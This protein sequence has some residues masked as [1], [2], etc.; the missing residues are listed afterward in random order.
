MD[1]FDIFIQILNESGKKHGYEK[2]L[3]ISHL[4]NITKLVS[5]ISNK[6]AQKQQQEEE[7][8][9]RMLDEAYMEILADQCCDRD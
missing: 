9:E 3:T 1:K 7:R 5:K 8:H 6:A 2:P 4:L